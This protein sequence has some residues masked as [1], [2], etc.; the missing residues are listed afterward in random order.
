MFSLGYKDEAT[1]DSYKNEMKACL[2]DYSNLEGYEEVM[3]GYYD[4]I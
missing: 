2:S 1:L 3:I 4:Y